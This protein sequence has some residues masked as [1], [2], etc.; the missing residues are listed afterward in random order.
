M[1]LASYFDPR[2]MIVS[3]RAPRAMGQGSYAWFD[4]EFTPEGVKA[5]PEQAAEAL[6]TLTGFLQ[7]LPDAYEHD[8]SRVLLG[9]FSQG[10]ILSLGVLL[11]Q[12]QSV[13][14]VI[15]LSARL[16]PDA[17][18]H[19][20]REALAGKPVLVTHGIYDTVIPIANGREIRAALSELPV[21]LTYKEY[22]MAHE[23]NGDALRDV[24]AWLEIWLRK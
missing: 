1:G 18:E 19:A 9:G 21:D 15:A 20:D 2:L 8:P 7:E 24:L 23:I 17:A 14:G 13:G 22:P 3:V 10:A 12:P 6:T 16:W 5:D 11:H 4:L